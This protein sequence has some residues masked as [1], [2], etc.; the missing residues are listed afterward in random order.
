MKRTIQTSLLVAVIA[1]LTA[2]APIAQTPA[3]TPAPALTLPRAV[4][5]AY[6]AGTRSAKVRSAGVARRR[7][8]GLRAR[9]SSTGGG[10]RFDMCFP[11]NAYE[12]GERSSTGCVR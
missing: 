2:C 7:N 6:A 11:R 1:L 5:S 3:P 8:S 9:I 4:A 10:V 12:Q